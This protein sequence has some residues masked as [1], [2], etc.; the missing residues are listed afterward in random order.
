[1][2]DIEAEKFK[3][4]VE[5]LGP[6]NI[7]AIATSGHDNQVTYQLRHIHRISCI[8]NTDDFSR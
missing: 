7:A 6:E 8:S 1:M 2:A 4:M 3:A 5:D